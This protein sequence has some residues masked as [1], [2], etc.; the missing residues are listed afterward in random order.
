MGFPVLNHSLRCN[1]YFFSGCR[2]SGMLGFHYIESARSDPFYKR[3][4]MLELELVAFW[5]VHQ[6]QITEY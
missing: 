5:A 4:S 3:L 6:V 1:C 2:N